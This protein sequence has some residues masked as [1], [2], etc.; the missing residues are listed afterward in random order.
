MPPPSPD[1]LEMKHFAKSLGPACGRS[2]VLGRNAFE[3]GDC[4]RA[5]RPSDRTIDGSC[6]VGRQGRAVSRCSH[7]T[8]EATFRKVV[9]AL[10]FVS[11]A[12]LII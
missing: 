9:L 11:G 2:A 5:R 1:D 3:P 12:A 4:N 8:A 6:K 10:L 7:V